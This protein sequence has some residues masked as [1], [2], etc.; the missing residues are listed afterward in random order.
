[1]DMLTEIKAQLTSISRKQDGL[2]E[3]IVDL[4]NE[5]KTRTESWVLFLTRRVEYT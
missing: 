1:M 2:I 5:L 4:G 3:L